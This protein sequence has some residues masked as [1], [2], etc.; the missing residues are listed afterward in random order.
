VR[1][2]TKITED[3]E[4]DRVEAE[5]ERSERELVRNGDPPMWFITVL[6]E[7]NVRSQK[8]S[9]NDSEHLRYPPGIG[10]DM[11]APPPAMQGWIPFH[12][13]QKLRDDWDFGENRYAGAA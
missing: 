5:P 2:V 1:P 10:I 3:T 11:T 8:L 7:S 6:V 9:F 13:I 4:F 12:R